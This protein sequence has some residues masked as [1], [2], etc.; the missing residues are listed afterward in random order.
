MCSTVV[1][2]TPVEP[3]VPALSAG[4]AANRLSICAI[5]ESVVSRAITR[6]DRHRRARVEAPGRP[7]R[8]RVYPARRPFRRGL[9]HRT[10]SSSM[11]LFS[12]KIEHLRA[13][14][15]SDGFANEALA[16]GEAPCL[17]IDPDFFTKLGA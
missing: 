16:R 17:V 7:L 5:G 10:W 4:A 9:R 1:V 14:T 3:V 11:T 13:L 15:E 12:C 6:D 2:A 8:E